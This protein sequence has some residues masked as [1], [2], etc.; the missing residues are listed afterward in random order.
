L[1]KESIQLEM[2][3]SR[4]LEHPANKKSRTVS[5]T[6]SNLNYRIRTAVVIV[7]TDAK[8]TISRNIDHGQV[9][10]MPRLSR[11]NGRRGASFLNIWKGKLGK[12]IVKGLR[13][14]RERSWLLGIL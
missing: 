7:L 3:S 5:N 2:Q 12:R 14:T 4:V 9:G 1:K 6:H 8:R 11:L 13:L 10:W